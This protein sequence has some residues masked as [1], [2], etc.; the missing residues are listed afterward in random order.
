[1]KKQ[2]YASSKYATFQKKI[3]PFSDPL[4]KTIG[5]S[6]SPLITR[7]DKH[8]AKKEKKTIIHIKI[9]CKIKKFKFEK[10]KKLSQ[11]VIFT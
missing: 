11:M 6:N 7:K 2:F 4:S 10:K 8:I 9:G 1:M 5:I 3:G